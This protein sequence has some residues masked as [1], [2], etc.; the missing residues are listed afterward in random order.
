MTVIVS[1]PYTANVD[2]IRDALADYGFSRDQAD[3]VIRYT[4][5]DTVK[6]SKEW[7]VDGGFVTLRYYGLSRFSLEDHTGN[8]QAKRVVQRP[9][10]GY[11]RD[12]DPVN[13][14]KETTMAPKPRGR[15]APA[16]A[17]EPEV[18]QVDFTPY[19]EK[20]LSATMADYAVWFRDNVGDPDQIDSDR[21][22]ALGSSLYTHFQRSDFNQTRRTER[23][24]AR[25]AEAAP[26]PTAPATGR[27]RGRGARGTAPAAPAAGP[28]R[29]RRG[30][31]A[32]AAAAPEAAY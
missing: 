22:L 7:K 30:R 21:L 29:G 18:E 10:M 1:Q 11:S 28:G 6:R 14:G 2:D 20:P 8:Q 13:R 3:E 19:L 23:R 24:A 5:Q 16:P 27:G 15:Q 26:E 32:A 17:P 4:V 31:P 9:R 12:S 25:E